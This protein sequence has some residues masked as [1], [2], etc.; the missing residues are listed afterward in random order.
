MINGILIDAS[1]GTGKP[2]QPRKTLAFLR[3]I[4]ERD[5]GIGLGVAGGLC[6]ATLD[7]VEPLLAEF[8]D[9]SIDAEGKL[10][11]QED[12][13][14]VKVAQTYLLRALQMFSKRAEKV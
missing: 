2:L 4:R 8:S 13:L 1:G 10:R 6:S 7:L 14:D 5:S 11:T 12:D 9:L 3:A